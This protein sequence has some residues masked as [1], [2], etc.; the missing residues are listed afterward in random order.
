MSDERWEMI[1]QL[2]S[3]GAAFVELV[4]RLDDEQW[5]RVPRD[6]G[7]SPAA[8]AEH[9]TIVEVSTGKLIARKLF[10]EP[11]G[12]EMLAAAARNQ[13]RLLSRVRTR[14]FRIEAPDFVTPTGRWPDRADLLATFQ[15]NREM[16]IV[17]LSDPTRELRRFVA[18]HPVLGPLDGCQWG[19]FL[20]LHLQR[21]M[22]QIEEVL[23]TP[24]A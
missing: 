13:A 4:E 18:P 11:A 5:N 23:A 3:T 10:T 14:D 2:Q 24:A 20:A 7:W 9:I 6:G 15:T 16:V 19:S 8:V 12:E 1:D 17:H 22:E 21:H